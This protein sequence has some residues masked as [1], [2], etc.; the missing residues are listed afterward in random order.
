VKLYELKAAGLE[1]RFFGGVTLEFD[2]TSTN[3]GTPGGSRTSAADDADD[4]LRT[5]RELQ[6]EVGEGC[7]LALA[8]LSFLFELIL[9]LILN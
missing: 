6:T 5:G 4:Q 9:N 3:T 8:L 2:A 7:A 1:G